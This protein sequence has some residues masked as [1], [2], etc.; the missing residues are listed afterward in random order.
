MPR[1]A[2]GTCASTAGSMRTDAHQHSTLNEP[3]AAGAQSFGSPHSGQRVFGKGVL[4][5]VSA[6]PRRHPT[7]DNSGHDSQ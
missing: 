6:P 5:A 1:C 4:I 3:Q 2:G 7:Q